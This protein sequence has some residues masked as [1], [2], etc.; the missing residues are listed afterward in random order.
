MEIYSALKQELISRYPNDINQYTLGKEGFI[1]N[2]DFRAA[3]ENKEAYWIPIT[4]LRKSTWSSTEIIDAMEANLELAMTY[5]ASYIPAEDRI[6]EKDIVLTLSSIPDETFN[7]VAFARFTV[8]NV[9]ERIDH[10]IKTYQSLPFSWWVSERDTPDLLIKHLE[11]KCLKYK[12]DDIGMCFFLDQLFFEGNQASPLQIQRVIGKETLYDFSKVMVS[13]GR[14]S[15]IYI[16]II[17]L[18]QYAQRN[19]ISIH[20]HVKLS[21]EEKDQE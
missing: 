11:S 1:K 4:S 12:E 18:Y 2:I 8:K 21:V 14:F 13:L 6:L 10:V 5:F 15:T 7:T 19:E 20:Y 16:Q 9:S 17:N 3:N